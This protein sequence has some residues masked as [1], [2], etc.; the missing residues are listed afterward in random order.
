MMS[1]EKLKNKKILMIALPGY[2]EGIVKKMRSMGAS[3]DYIS[4]KPNEGVICKTLGRLQVKWYQ[5]VLEHY[6]DTQIR[7]IKDKS[8]DY[9]LVIRGEYTPINT[10]IKIK[11]RYPESKLILY[12]WDSLKNNRQIEKKWNYYDKVFSFDRID[13]LNNKNKISFLPLYYYEEYL[14]KMPLKKNDFKYMISFIGTGHEDRIKIIKDVVEQC[15]IMG[16]STYTYLFLPHKLI[17]LKNK[18]MNPNFKGVKISEIQFKKK[19]FKEVYEVYSES[20]CVM[21]IES[22]AQTGLTMRT[23]E[24]L[25]LKRKFITTNKDIINYDFYNPNNILVVD[26][27]NVKIDKEFLKKPYE[28]LNDSIYKKY[29]LENWIISV[30]N[31]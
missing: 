25:G 24:I 29:S 4:D 28:E 14:P 27:K 26:R 17:Y 8:Y 21:D 1:K 13:C 7:K 2:S 12:M 10:L 3:V 6:Y 23:I 31:V 16:M 22:A 20:K 11:Q 30:L 19:P 5:K 15:S 9:V 18:L